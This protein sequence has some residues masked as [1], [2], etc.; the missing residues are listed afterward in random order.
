MLNLHQLIQ[1]CV[2]VQEVLM[3]VR[4]ELDFGVE[5]YVGVRRQIFVVVGLQSGHRVYL[6]QLVRVQRR[7]KFHQG[8]LALH[9]LDLSLAPPHYFRTWLFFLVAFAPHFN[10]VALF[11]TNIAFCIHSFVP[12]LVPNHCH[13]LVHRLPDSNLEQL[14]SAPV[15]QLLV[16]VRSVRVHDVPDL[17]LQPRVLVRERGEHLHFQMVLVWLLLLDA[18]RHIY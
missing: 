7:V 1:E 10:H 11:E 12:D 4:V 16:G 14:V 15:M 5:E 2:V 17:T 6:R 13:I 8:I 9:V 18:C 3:E